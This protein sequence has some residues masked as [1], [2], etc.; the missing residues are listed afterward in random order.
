MTATQQHDTPITPTPDWTAAVR[1]RCWG[2]PERNP[3]LISLTEIARRIGVKRQTMTT[4][5][6]TRPDWFPFSPV[7]IGRSPISGGPTRYYR[8]SQVEP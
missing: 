7:T 3:Y 8:R 2:S 4:N 5:A 6:C 1:S